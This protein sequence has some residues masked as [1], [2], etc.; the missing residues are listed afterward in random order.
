MI[1][2]MVLSEIDFFMQSM[3]VFT[4][5]DK[6]IF[7]HPKDKKH[8]E[9]KYTQVASSDCIDSRTWI[10]VDDDI[11]V[12]LQNTEQVTKIVDLV[13]IV[14]DGLGYRPFAPVERY[15][16]SYYYVF[17]DFNRLINLIPYCLDYV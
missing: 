4:S 16:A 13:D 5:I 15:V 14:H 6:K 8:N 9:C 17:T 7:L 1:K 10:H 3:W 2:D 12:T 11:L